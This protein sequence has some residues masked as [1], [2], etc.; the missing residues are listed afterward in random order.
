MEI[1]Q[2]PDGYQTS[3]GEPIDANLVAALSGSLA[4][5]RP[6]G[7]LKTCVDITDNYP[8]WQIDMRY[9]D[10]RQAILISNSNCL[11]GIPWNVIYQGE[12]YA[13]Y[14]GD[15]SMA[16]MPLLGALPGDPFEVG[17]FDPVAEAQRREETLAETELVFRV[18][19]GNVPAV[20]REK[21]VSE[22]ALYTQLL[23]ASPLFEPFVSGYEVV[24]LELVCPL[25]ANNPDCADLDGFLT[26]E[27]RE[28][29]T[30]MSLFVKFEGPEV[31]EINADIPDV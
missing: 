26:L 3:S 19:E 5:L 1:F 31:I 15:I 16:L 8:R 7:G 30:Q 12:L 4:H 20:V 25:S 22:Q 17:Q 11:Y 24:N 14:T 28:N 9:R 6:S 2:T 18:T 10:G 23:T 13:Q 21:R 27:S 29:G